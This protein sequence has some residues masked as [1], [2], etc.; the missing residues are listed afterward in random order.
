MKG[1]MPDDMHKNAD[2]L[3]PEECALLK[4]TLLKSFPEDE[5]ESFVRICQR[6]RLDPFVKQIYATR[7]YSKIRDDSG[8][9][10]KVPTLVPVTGI[11]G[12]CAIAD[13]TGHYDGAEVYWCGPDGEW[14]S[15]WVSDEFPAAAKCVV[16]HKE[17][18][19]PEVA[20]AR[21]NS[22][23]G[24]TYNYQTKQ[25]EVGDFWAK[26]PD[27]MLA[28]CAKAAA[29]RGAFP[30]P[31]SNV[32]I[33][34]ELESN[35][36]DAEETESIPAD[37]AKIAENQR[38]EAELRDRPLPTGVKLVESKHDQPRPTPAEAL[39]PAFEQDKIPPKTTAPAPPPHLT[40]AQP[41]PAAV[42]EDEIDM[43][44]AVPTPPP[45]PPAWR[46]H[47]I[48]GIID[49]RFNGRKVADLTQKELRAI[50][51]Q[52][53]TKVRAA[54]DTDANEAQQADAIAFEAAIAFYKSEASQKPW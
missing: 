40:A 32:Y 25:W 19:H 17:R 26:M 4:R 22:Y 43:T 3:S 31:M 41:V 49:K 38:R 5:Q 14:K 34:E 6:T 28:K 1:N 23:V 53:L 51:A 10:R 9:T 48:K 12:L 16:H 13:R 21:W 18:K 54:W 50:E 45:V 44:P 24:Q 15:E 30:D 52:W 36:T 27:Y 33:R 2:F 29:L 37:E 46:D 20:I 42:E 39:E 7:R 8:E 35:L 11:M 47:V